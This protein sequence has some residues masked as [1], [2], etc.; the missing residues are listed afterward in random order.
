MRSFPG[1]RCREQASDG[2]KCLT[3]ARF[4][5]LSRST[6]PPEEAAPPG[7]AVPSPRGAGQQGLGFDPAAAGPLALSRQRGSGRGSRR[8]GAA[9][10]RQ[11]PTANRHRPQ[12]PV[13][14]EV[15]VP[16]EEVVENLK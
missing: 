6:L 9:R 4:R 7:L 16:D 11:P 14:R 8:Q 3:G 2:E 13:G 5:R 1:K 10:H 12:P 15:T